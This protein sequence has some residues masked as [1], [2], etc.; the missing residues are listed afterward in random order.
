MRPASRPPQPSR[1]Y[2]WWPGAPSPSTISVA[3]AS[4]S[5]AMAKRVGNTAARRPVSH[6]PRTEPSFAQPDGDSLDLVDET[7]PHVMAASESARNSLIGQ[8]RREH[9]PR[10][11]AQYIV[12][13][14]QIDGLASAPGFV[15]TNLVLQPAAGSL[16]ACVADA[17]IGRAGGADINR[18]AKASGLHPARYAGHSLRAAL[19]T[20][21]AAA[22][23]SERV[24][25]SQTGHRSA[26]MVR[27]YSRAG[28]LFR[29]NAAGRG[30]VMSSFVPCA[31][32]CP[33]E[34]P[35]LDR[36]T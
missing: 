34:Q 20:N 6:I 2:D 28:S 4:T 10:G 8:T 5:V 1:R 16:S 22:A 36:S 27:R 14:I 23:A 24:T 9:A 29:E 30:W 17:F 26:H 13:G 32:R 19:A 3:S 21:A 25:M 15:F 12:G 33:E 18:R 31:C 35:H 11:R 7:A